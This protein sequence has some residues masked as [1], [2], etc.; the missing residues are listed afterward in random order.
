M[1][2]EIVMSYLTKQNIADIYP[3]SPMQQGMLFHTLYDSETSAYFE[4]FS[5][6]IE[7]PL[8]LPCLEKAWNHLIDAYPVFRTVFNWK[9][10]SK[11]VQI[12]LK[13][14]PIV[15]GVHDIKDL[16]ESSQKE[17]IRDFLAKDKAS[18]FDLGKG[19]L[20]RLN[21]IELGHNV[22]YFL[23]SYHHI[24]LDGWCLSLI[25]SDFFSSYT[26]LKSGQPLSRITR[27]PYKEYIAWLSR[28]DRKKAD[29]FW[30]EYLRDFDTPTALPCDRPHEGGLNVKEIQLELSEE[31]T[32][33]LEAFA[34]E[35]R[36][37]LS[38]VI[39]GIWAVQLSRYSGTDDCVFGIT[40]S[41]RPPQLKGSDAMVGLFINTLPVRALI[42]RQSTFSSFLK[43]F[44][45]SS[46][47]VMEYEYSFLPDIRACS[48]VSP[49]MNLFDSIIVFENYPLDT[50]A[51]G[52]DMKV[53]DI[54]AKEATNYDICIVCAPGK[55]LVLKYLY[56]EEKLYP[57]S[58]ERIKGHTLTLISEVL[59]KPDTPLSELE[60][61]TPEEYEQVVT[62]FNSTRRPFPEDR[63]PYQLFEEQ[64][65]KTPD[66]IAVSFEGDSINYK[67]LNE[68]ANRLAHY[69]RS[70]GVGPESKVGLMVSRSIDMLVAI[71]G[72]HKAGG[73]Y[74]PMDPEYPGARLEYMLEDSESPVL[75]TQS[76][77][78]DRITNRPGNIVLLDNDWAEIEKESPDNPEP[79]AGPKN[80]SHLIYTSGSTGVPKGVMIEHRNVTA[81]LYWCLDE[82][83]FDEYEEMIY[84]TSMCFD[85][86]IF[87]ML[88]PLTT[89]A[90]VIV[91][92]SSLDIDDYL[93]AGGTVTMVNTVPSALKHLVNI[94][95]K[96]YRIKAIC[97]AGEPLKLDLVKDAYARLDVDVIRNLYGPTE[98]TTYSTGFRVPK[99][100]DRQ[101]L[102]GK[103][104]S[105]GQAYI[106]D[107]NLKPVPIG[108]LG[109]I[110]LS[111]AGLARGYWNAPEKTA[112]RFLPNPFSTGEY[113][114]IYKT[115]D[116]G[117]WL[118]DGNIEFHGRVDYQVKIRG[119]RIEMG[120]I[121]AR[122]AEHEKISDIV[123]IDK[124]DREGNKFLVAY[125]VA[126][127][128]LS[129]SELR[130]FL[131]E[132][133]PDYMVPSRMIRLESLPL[134]PNGK[135][136]RKALPEPEGMQPQVETEYV[137]PRDKLEQL[138]AQI[139]QE[140]LGV[141]RIGINDNFFELGGDSIISLQVVS[142]LKK[143]GYEI[144][145]RDIFEHQSIAELVT[146]VKHAASAVADQ[147]AVVGIAPLTPVQRW[148]FELPLVNRNHFNQALMFKSNI[149]LDD[150]KLKKALQAII[151]NHDVLRARFMPDKQEF[152]PIG[153]EAKLTV[154]SV[155]D[156]NMDNEI[157]ALQS[158]LDI[159]KGPLIA[160]GLYHAPGCDYLLLAA[161]HL[162]IDGVSWRILLEDLFEGYAA[163]S[164][165]KA[166]KLPAKTTSF[167]EWS[168]KQGQYAS[169]KDVQKESGF[170]EKSLAD[171]KVDLPLDI[172]SG[173]NIME[174]ADVVTIDIDEETTGYLLRDAHKAYGTEVNDLLITALMQII[175]KWTGSKS[176]A[177]TLEGH[178]REDV[179][180]DV[181][182]SRTVGWFTTMYPVVLNCPESNDL[183]DHVKYVKECLHTI[184]F[185]GFNFGVLKYLSGRDWPVNMGISFNY[186]GQL[187]ASGLGGVLDLAR[188]D[189]PFTVDGRNPRANL[190]DI[191][192]AVK[193]SQLS[194]NMVF[195]TNKH[196]K[197]TIMKLAEKYRE[198]LVKIISH[199]M[200]PESFDVTPSDFKLAKLDQEDL[201]NIYE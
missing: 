154:K 142:R 140:V 159:G 163:L 126:S 201:D 42:D 47:S 148:F 143:D 17:W 177:F 75:V 144:R 103:P 185:R 77:L 121:E 190:I 16:D 5:C 46:T 129:I 149:R 80:L 141:D 26:T 73:G 112:Q 54:S 168:I 105:N 15:L 118:S 97:L 85:L 40:V 82:F 3:L 72:I 156:E 66:N 1:N 110:Y 13:K 137:A 63:C 61:M 95:G 22:Y 182:I 59:N 181:D 120:E 184:P 117:R 70:K 194:I 7:G 99:D 6:R 49:G 111:G 175:C 4:Q 90:R 136:D 109:E 187:A 2:E 78:L 68:R 62:G 60:I 31:T 44:K 115:G 102:I 98:D 200:K 88:L 125:Y 173:P 81:F 65:L 41:G 186:L 64:V 170:W 38:T 127:E 123:V 150:E 113:P 51:V 193:G 29:Q 12:V 21:V 164:D 92:K 157:K 167:L 10:T 122:L 45:E 130:A 176:I 50:F 153:A 24:L 91:L 199:C 191:I 161:H 189:V 116:L 138:I 14:Y 106:L 107:K 135:V 57:E 9:D 71:L 155:S 34:R 104:L 89:G 152:M 192:C 198:E 58:M 56:N 35:Q 93:S 165:G 151:D 114:F 195:S 52:S 43:K 69:L 119:N 196:N 19:P 86:S 33:R 27:P 36:T 166:I 188:A 147:G 131:K 183:G 67:G 158:S 160:A 128:E 197:E 30:G 74:V 79:V 139:W 132:K 96:R 180:S 11:P 37:T 124:D 39:Q 83:T 18:S 162:A 48:A 133:L 28:Q 174:T 171:L 179:I 25:M 32:N 108:V 94:A 53:S 101:P 172:D 23:W 169:G 76:F 20:M 55:K 134:T 87:E 8:D 145:P 100:F 84:S 178:G 146:V